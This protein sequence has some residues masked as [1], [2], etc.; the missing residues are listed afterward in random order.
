MI[1]NFLVPMDCRLKKIM[2]SANQWNGDTTVSMS[3]ETFAPGDS[4]LSS[5]N[6]NLIGQVSVA[7]DH[8]EQAHHTIV[9]DFENDLDAGIGSESNYVKAGHRALIGV[10]TTD[11]VQVGSGNLNL[12]SIWEADYGT[13]L[14]ASTA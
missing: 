9:M 10:I 1:S 4:N 3:L 7:Y 13:M 5:G 14:T 8:S 12:T 2:W 6:M 11:D